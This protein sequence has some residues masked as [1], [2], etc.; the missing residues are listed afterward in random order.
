MALLVSVLCPGSEGLAVEPVELR[1]LVAR[2]ETI[3]LGQVDVLEPEGPCFVSVGEVLKGERRFSELRLEIDS[4]DKSVLETVRPFFRPNEPVAVLIRPRGR[5]PAL[6]CCNGVWMQ[7][8]ERGRGEPNI[9]RWRIMG[10]DEAAQRAFVGSVDLLGLAVQSLR[11]GRGPASIRSQRVRPSPLRAAKPTASLPACEGLEAT[12]TWFRESWSDPAGVAIVGDGNRQLE[13]AF[14]KGPQSKTIV[15][16]AYPANLSDK[17]FVV[18]DLANPSSASVNVAMGL[19]TTSSHQ[20]FEA[21]PQ[22]VP[23]R[24]RRSLHFDLS[25]ATYKCAAQNWLH[26]SVIANRRH[27]RS[28]SICVYHTIT[29]EAIGKIQVD[30]VRVADVLFEEPVPCSVS[31][32]PCRHLSRVDDDGDGLFSY[33]SAARQPFLHTPAKPGK[34]KGSVTFC[35][36]ARHADWADY[37]GDGDFDLLLSPLALYINRG[38]V[39][40][41]RSARLPAPLRKADTRA[42]WLDHDGDGLP[43]ILL[44]GNA[45]PPVLLRNQSRKAPPFA[46]VTKAAHLET[47]HV[48][49]LLCCAD[50]N[51]DAQPDFLFNE[52]APVL[53]ISQGGGTFELTTK[54]GLPGGKGLLVVPGDYDNDGDFDLF[55]GRAGAAELYRNRGHAVFANAAELLGRLPT[56]PSGCV[57]AT[58]GDLNRDGRL[59]LYLCRKDAPGQ[60]L[61]GSRRGYFSDHTFDCNLLRL[62]D[63][64]PAAASTMADLDEDGDLDL[65]VYTPLGRA[66]RFSNRRA[67]AGN[68]TSLSVTLREGETRRPGFVTVTSAV[69]TGWGVREVG[70]AFS[71][72]THA[73]PV[74]FFGVKPGSY[75]I[76]AQFLDG[77]EMSQRVL[78]ARDPASVVLDLE[79]AKPVTRQYVVVDGLASPGEWSHVKEVKAGL[80]YRD[81]QDGKEVR[82]EMSIRCQA[83]AGYLY[84]C[85]RVDGQDPFDEDAPDRLELLFDRDANGMMEVGDDVKAFVATAYSDMYFAGQ[86]QAKADPQQQGFGAVTHSNPKGK[87][88][89]LFEVAIPVDPPDANDAALRPRSI[90]GFKVIYV[91]RSDERCI[92]G[93]PDGQRYHGRFAR[94]RPARPKDGAPVNVLILPPPE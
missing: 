87:G 50:L 43:D 35:R 25:T 86:G 88:S 69:G 21:Q 65:L 77:R 51:G 44:T 6:A 79:Q 17:G 46:D 38:G 57:A 81:P 58:W 2:A 89:H 75:S 76:C 84:L 53:A 49:E 90:V 12:G 83:R 78:V 42:T 11:T 15:S 94:M 80:K 40:D 22:A 93:F 10:V 74:A 1:E 28:L 9:S 33:F 59:D 52:E 34:R 60:L 20:Y 5:G 26:T 55:V 32:G 37:D 91:P 47:K 27:V 45:R 48:G 62:L 61:L 7:L 31:G 18:L 23:A 68:T 41:D 36:A 24:G 13:I 71:T 85:V 30:N 8:A 56:P 3:V 73:A 63:G 66:G 4:A 39:L 70:H 64:E 29:T 14:R 67:A 19:S 72:G 16:R 54:H 82:H 92:A